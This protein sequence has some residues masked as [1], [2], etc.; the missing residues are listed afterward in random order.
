MKIVALA[1]LTLALA[2]PAFA[3]E[4]PKDAVVKPAKPAKVCKPD[5]SSTGS[6]IPKKIC[7]TREQWNT[8]DGVQELGNKSR[9]GAIEGRF[10]VERPG[11]GGR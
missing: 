6:R 3:E 11:P 10:N 4:P 1:V 2:A 8:L 5:H 7:K 9:G